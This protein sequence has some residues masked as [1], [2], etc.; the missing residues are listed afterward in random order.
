MWGKQPVLHPPP[1]MQRVG[2]R[3]RTPLGFRVLAVGGR[4]PSHQDTPFRPSSAATWLCDLGQITPLP[5][6]LESSFLIMI[7]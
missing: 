3:G 5:E 2:L 6:T 1:P 4:W 7:P